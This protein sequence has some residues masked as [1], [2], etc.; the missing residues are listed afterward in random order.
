MEPPQEG[1]RASVRAFADVR[2][3]RQQAKK[4]MERAQHLIETAQMLYTRSKA[5]LARIMGTKRDTQ[6]ARTEAVPISP[7]DPRSC[8]R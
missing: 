5:L 6:E 7:G 4:L 8:N 1:N 3:K 2:A